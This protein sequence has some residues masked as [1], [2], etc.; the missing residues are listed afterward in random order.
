MSDSHSDAFVF[1][2]ATGDLAYEKI[3]LSL[4]AIVKRRTLD[5][6]VIGVAR[7]GWNLEQFHS[8]AYDSVEKHGG[9]ERAAFDKLC[10][11]LRYVEGDYNDSATF[12]AIRQELGSRERPAHNLAIPPMLFELVVEQLGKSVCVE[13]ARVIIEKP[14]GTDLISART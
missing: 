8:R 14:F 12:K 1:F 6:P 5:L 9:V 2:G 10:S 7:S 13:G 4:Q 3:F 11:L